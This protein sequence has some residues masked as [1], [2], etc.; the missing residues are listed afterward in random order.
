VGDDEESVGPK[1][2][3]LLLEAHTV[4]F[5]V[6]QERK[7]DRVLA[8]HGLHL[9][10]VRKPAAV[11]GPP[12]PARLGLVPPVQ[13]EDA[14]GREDVPSVTHHLVPD[15]L[16][17]QTPHVAR[18]RVPADEGVA[19]SGEH[20]PLCAH[21][22]GKVLGVLFERRGRLEG[23]RGPPLAAF[24]VGRPR[25]LERAPDAGEQRGLREVA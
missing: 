1:D 20:E 15:L 2:P 10:P 16:R 22:Q 21:A 17:A 9:L 6:R 7:L 13:H 12:A 5:L 8:Q 3:H 24:V 4:N 25:V 14:G 18:L 19:V 11:P 23:R